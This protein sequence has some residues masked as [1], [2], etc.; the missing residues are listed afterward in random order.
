MRTRARLSRAQ[1]AV[2]TGRAES[3]IRAHETG[4]NKISPEAAAAYATALS[5]Q[6]GYILWGFGPPPEQT[7]ISSDTFFKVKVVGTVRNHYFVKLE[8]QGKPD[9]DFIIIP[10]IV[11]HRQEDLRA[12]RD[13][14]LEVETSTVKYLIVT[15][16]R[17]GR[18]FKGDQVIGRTKEGSLSETA[19]WNVSADIKSV[20]FAKSKTNRHMPQQEFTIPRG[21]KFP[22]GWELVGVVV[23][24][25]EM[26]FRRPSWQW[27]V[28]TTEKDISE[29]EFHL[30]EQERERQ[31]DEEAEADRLAAEEEEALS[32]EDGD[33]S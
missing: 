13:F 8:E 29:Y 18:L 19:T 9:P 32:E 3:T 2:K 25:I 10:K 30:E 28:M 5:I 14:S 1:L 7:T 16:Y 15:P 27:D 33:E 24:R 26:S 22:P 12:F 17:V 11:F 31:R 23:G 20:T 21:A 6:P 4:Q